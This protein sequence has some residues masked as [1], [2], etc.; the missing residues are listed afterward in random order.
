MER[1]RVVYLI[2]D[3]N[4]SAKWRIAG[5]AFV[6]KDGS[7]NL[8][9]DMFPALVFNIRPVR[10]NSEAR[11]LAHGAVYQKAPEEVT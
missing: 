4:G 2:T 9:L 7:T 8:R 10:N 3:N 11:E 5:S 6:C 1:E